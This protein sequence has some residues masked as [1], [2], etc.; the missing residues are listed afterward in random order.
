MSIHALIFRAKEKL[1]MARMLMK[2][3][4]EKVAALQKLS[5]VNCLGVACHAEK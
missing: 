5:Q 4:S 3:K 2:A 1:D